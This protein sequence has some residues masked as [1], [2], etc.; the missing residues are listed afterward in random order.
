M[1]YSTLYYDAANLNIYINYNFKNSTNFIR[2]F[3]L[4]FL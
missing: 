2:N 3:V 1:R 4:D